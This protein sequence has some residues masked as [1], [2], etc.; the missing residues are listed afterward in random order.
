MGP[1]QERGEH[2]HGLAFVEAKSLFDAD[3][4]AAMDTRQGYGE[5][6]WR[7]IGELNDRVLVV[8]WTGRAPGKRRII[9]LRRAN[10]RERTAYYKAVQDGLGKG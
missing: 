4:Y 9:S 5:E 10:E 7:G 8:V 2:C 3:V 6:C 1:C